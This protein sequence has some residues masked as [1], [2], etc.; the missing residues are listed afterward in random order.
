MLKNFK[1]GYAVSLKSETA[2][3]EA[4]DCAFMSI[5]HSRNASGTID[6][7]RLEGSPLI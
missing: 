5:P 6:D 2:R 4:N 7:G 3:N 1:N